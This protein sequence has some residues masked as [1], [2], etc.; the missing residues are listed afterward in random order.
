MCGCVTD[1]II[2]IGMVDCDVA[3]LENETDHVDQ[4]DGGV[5]LDDTIRC[6]Q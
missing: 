6:P 2:S 4:D 1:L 5:R 3:E